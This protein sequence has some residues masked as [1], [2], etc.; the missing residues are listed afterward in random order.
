[1][2]LQDR[3]KALESMNTAL[4][5]EKVDIKAALDRALAKM[6]E[7]ELSSISWCPIDGQY[8]SA[9]CSPNTKWEVVKLVRVRLA[10]NG[11]IRCTVIWKPSEVEYTALVGEALWRQFHNMFIEE[12]GLEEWRRR[13]GSMRSSGDRSSGDRRQ[14]R[15]GNQRIEK[16]QSLQR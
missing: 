6:E 16:R 12:C 4:Q 2:D 9:S 10:D 8:D 13:F 5:T 3:I 1:L 14:R 11:S 15:K 7:L